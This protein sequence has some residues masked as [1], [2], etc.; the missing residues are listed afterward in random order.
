[1]AAAAVQGEEARGY[2]LEEQGWQ[3]LISLA[4]SANPQDRRIAVHSAPQPRCRVNS[5]RFGQNLA[6]DFQTPAARTPDHTPPQPTHPTAGNRGAAG[7][8][9][10]PTPVP[11]N[12]NAC[13]V[14]ERRIEKAGGGAPAM[15]S[16]RFLAKVVA[17]GRPMWR[18][19]REGEEGGG[20]REEGGGGK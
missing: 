10:G 4:W 6:L 7:S 9:R 18:W 16:Q 12:P 13:H 3:P 11:H 20:G 14:C 17:L 1:M 19:R 8:A 15:Y 2:L 5:A